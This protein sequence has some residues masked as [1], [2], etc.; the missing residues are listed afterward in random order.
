MNLDEISHR[1]H[2]LG[3]QSTFFM[4]ARQK[5]TRRRPNADYS[6]RNKRLQRQLHLAVSMGAEIGVHG[7]WGSHVDAVQLRA[8]IERVQSSSGTEIT[9]SRFHFLNFATDRTPQV[10]Q[11]SRLAY[12]ST[13]AFAEHCG[14]RNG[15][16]HPFFLY[17]HKADR[18]TDVVEIPLLLMDTTLAGKRYMA[19][20][21]GDELDAVIDAL[22]AEVSH[23]SGVLSVLWHNNYF[24]DHKYAGWGECYWG[25]VDACQ[26][27]R[28]LF[29]TGSEI[30][31]RFLG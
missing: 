14:F 23:F 24:S 8:E 22:R 13:L 7:S 25:L 9:G 20:R 10:L 18:P 27:E 30:A 31:Q 1:E 2:D 11:E 6:L 19:L 4:L 28:G 17:D 29:L 16:C 3:V 5:G 15:F 21:P 26:R 12:D